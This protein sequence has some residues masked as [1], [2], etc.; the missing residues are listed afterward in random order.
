[1]SDKQYVDV[2]IVKVIEQ[3]TVD[4]KF[5]TAKAEVK[6]KD[7]PVKIKGFADK[8][9]CVVDGAVIHATWSEEYKNYFTVGAARKAGGGGGGR[10]GWRPLTAEESAALERAKYPSFAVSYWKDVLVALIES[11]TTPAAALEQTKTWPK[12]FLNKM[13]ELSGGAE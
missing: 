9:D 7:G 12:A 2:E 10:G 5:F 11:G 3:A 4:G 13:H 6:G 8:K 1:M